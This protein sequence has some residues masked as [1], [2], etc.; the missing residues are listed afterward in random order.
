MS[1]N[2]LALLF[3]VGYMILAVSARPV[4]TQDVFNGYNNTVVVI[5]HKDIEPSI[6]GPN[7]NVFGRVL[8]QVLNMTNHGVEKHPLGGLLLHL[9]N[10]FQPLDAPG[11]WK[12]FGHGLK[13]SFSTF[14]RNVPPMSEAVIKYLGDL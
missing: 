11:F 12:N 4:L 1:R 9:G 8:N 14:F 6:W 13:V 7:I 3:I 5:G 10:E 2:T